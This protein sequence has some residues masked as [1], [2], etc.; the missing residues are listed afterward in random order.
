M[1]V[2]LTGTLIEAAPTYCILDVQGVGY[3]L[4]ISSTCA[5]GLPEIGS[6]KVTLLCRMIVRED[7]MSLY[8]F[9]DAAERSLFD[10]LRAI[11]GVGPK[12]ALSV[13]STYT[14]SALATVVT[15]EDISALT[16]ISGVGKKTAQRLLI[17]LK[18]VFE[19][20]PSLK[21]LSSDLDVSFKA[22]AAISVQEDVVEALLS[23]GFTSE[24]A[25]V[26]LEGA[27][28]EDGATTQ[29]LLNYALKRLGGRR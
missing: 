12:L 8:G 18:S 22:P 27:S 6:S 19:K 7:D 16:K 1:I 17:E 2:Q 23:M 24:E 14:P 25:S 20:D 15:T 11:S 13:L 28:E 26:S 9:T 5:A 29:K 21:Y 3:E 4:G 10:K